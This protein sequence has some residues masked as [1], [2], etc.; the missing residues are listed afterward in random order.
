[1]TDTVSQSGT[2]YLLK[3][4]LERFTLPQ[5]VKVQE[6]YYDECQSATIGADAV[7]N[8]LSLGSVETALFEDADGNDTRFPLDDQFNVERVAEARY[9]QL[10][11]LK[12][13]F[14]EGSTVTFVRVVETDPNFETIIK[15]GE[16]LKI[17]RKKSRE[18]FMTFKKVN[19]K[20]KP[21]LKVPASC[22]AKFLPLWDGQELPL[23]KFVKTYKLPVYVMMNFIDNSTD[24]GTTEEVEI[25]REKVTTKKVSNRLFPDGVLKL[26]G[27][28]ADTFVVAS[29]EVEGV[30]SKFSFPKT[31]PISVVPLI[32]E[33][34][35]ETPHS[36]L[37][38]ISSQTNETGNDINEFLEGEENLYE[39]M[40]GIRTLQGSSQSTMV[41]KKEGKSKRGDKTMSITRL[42]GLAGA[43][44]NTYS[45]APSTKQTKV[46]RSQSVTLPGKVTYTPRRRGSDFQLQTSVREGQD[47]L[48][49]ELQF[50]ALPQGVERNPSF[51]ARRA[52]SDRSIDQ[53]SKQNLNNLLHVQAQNSKDQSFQ[54]QVDVVSLQ[55]PNISPAYKTCIRM[56]T[57]GR[58]GKVDE[59]ENSP[60]DTQSLIFNSCACQSFNTNCFPEKSTSLA[61]KAPFYG[62]V[63]ME[64]D[65]PSNQNISISPQLKRSRGDALPSLPSTK[66]SYEE[67]LHFSNRDLPV[68]E[69][70]DR[71]GRSNVV[72]VKVLSVG[73]CKKEYISESPER[74]DHYENVKPQQKSSINPTGIKES[75]T[76]KKEE[77][78]P[79]IPLRKK[80]T[81]EVLYSEVS[82]K[83]TNPSQ[84]KIARDGIANVKPQQ[85]SSISPTGL[86]EG[87]TNKKEDAPPL[88]PLRKK[89]TEEVLYSE[90]S[91]KVTNPSLNK[92]AT[93]KV[94]EPVPLPRTGK[95][96][97]SPKATRDE[98]SLSLTDQ[99]KSTINSSVKYNSTASSLEQEP[100]TAE[101]LQSAVE[102][103]P[104]SYFTIPQ[105][106]STLSVPE[107]L[108]CL[109]ALNMQKFEKIFS[110]H[111]VDGSM[112]VC[113]DEEALQS[114]GMDRFHR[115]KLLKVI[116]GW[117]PQL[118]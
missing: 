94:R 18:T 84:D 2:S 80:P 92:S 64:C 5:L 62:S 118:S 69:N 88:I 115:L 78:P 82:K 106:L 43:R 104:K 10:L 28:L 113:L 101:K 85:K 68:K 86:R 108:K 35:T 50:N 11:T 23:D 95:P 117:R 42:G 73:T 29:T 102:E 112:L 3:E 83:P 60:S 31:L 49:D 54:S 1:M 96:H 45:P 47:N 57:F 12:E 51:M 56:K 74:S 9:Q 53:V 77:D 41:G 15:K 27:I 6:G 16:K 44:H 61:T 99:H 109:N 59:T 25:S 4:F 55:I 72:G 107:V 38:F 30:P 40:S 103:F 46:V 7:Y 63:E 75:V 97:S 105:D 24:K 90:V 48:Y 52:S 32:R 67:E 33:A 89:Q 110:E 79:A 22:Q 111:Q 100:K 36:A 65:F 91:K 20:G 98:S 14:H 8:L 93:C 87:E 13:L 39:D 58:K 66:E 26:K 81:E 76:N 17:K 71:K 116:T 37:K 114:F 19:D 34:T 21:L 70:G